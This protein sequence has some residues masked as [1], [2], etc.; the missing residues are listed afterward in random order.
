LAH[1]LDDGAADW[2]CLGP[3]QRASLNGVAS[4]FLEIPVQ[5]QTPRHDMRGVNNRKPWWVAHTETDA[6]VLREYNASNVSASLRRLMN[7][8]RLTVAEVAQR[9]GLSESTVR[10]SLRRTGS[11]S[12][13]T[14]ERWLEACGLDSGK[15]ST[16]WAAAHRPTPQ[17]VR[18]WTPL[19]V[20]TFHDLT[21]ALNALYRAEGKPPLRDVTHRAARAGDHLPKSTLHDALSGRRNPSRETVRAL[22]RV[23]GVDEREV[24]WWSKAWDRCREQHAVGRGREPRDLIVPG[25]GLG[26]ATR[27]E[28]DV[29]DAVVRLIESAAASGLEWDV[30]AQAALYAA[31]F[32]LG[33]QHQPTSAGRSFPQESP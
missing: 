4:P 25:R 10:R 20:F 21:A 18:L 26:M 24:Q 31:Q 11:P 30:A 29:S 1:Q 9:T 33:P 14:L 19:N 23:F 27:A 8:R 7:Q 22:V 15:A 5:Q 28:H 6:L 17:A 32:C 16:L 13:R 12:L 3:H 2:P